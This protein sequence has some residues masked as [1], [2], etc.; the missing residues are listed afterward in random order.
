MPHVAAQ[1]LLTD[2]K[3]HFIRTFP[4]PKRLAAVDVVHMVASTEPSAINLAVLPW[5]VLGLESGHALRC[6]A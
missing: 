5:R 3:H 1:R 6:K 4:T 2:C